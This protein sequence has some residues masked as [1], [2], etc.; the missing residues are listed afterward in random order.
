[1]NITLEVLTRAID[2]SVERKKILVP[3]TDYY[4][5]EGDFDEQTIDY[6][7]PY[8][9]LQKLKEFTAEGD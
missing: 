4:R 5:R 8:T 6:L 1:M 2:H 7:D 9:L 3:S